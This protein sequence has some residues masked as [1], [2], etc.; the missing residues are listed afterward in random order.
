[1]RSTNGLGELEST[2]DVSVRGIESHMI[3]RRN[4]RFKVRGF[5]AAIF[6]SGMGLFSPPLAFTDSCMDP[7]DHP[8]KI[9]ALPSDDGITTVTYSA[10][11]GGAVNSLAASA[12][13]AWNSLTDETGVTFTA[14]SGSDVGD[15]QVGPNSGSHQAEDG[16]ISTSAR[17]GYINWGS[18]FTPDLTTYSSDGLLSFEH[19]IGHLLGLGDNT[20]NNNDLMDQSTGCTPAQEGYSWDGKSPTTSDA[21][22]AG[23]CQEDACNNS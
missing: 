4:S 10:M 11:G 1:M 6:L 21:T 19:E 5:S 18:N 23:T 2:R 3:R 8:N 22:Q 13:E 7:I 20:G 15:I 12:F 17:Y 14:A 16:C 9:A